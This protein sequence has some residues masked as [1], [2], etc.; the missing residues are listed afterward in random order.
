MVGSGPFGNSSG[1]NNWV[2]SYACVF[3][4]N[5]NLHLD[6]GSGH[7]LYL[8]MYTDGNIWIDGSVRYTSDDR[9][10][11]N[12]KKVVNALDVI[13]KLEVLTY[14]KSKKIC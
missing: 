12:E 7:T 2:A 1:Q 14:F 6:S 8:N 10:K 3:A 11:H 5:L 4:T 13:N 9:L